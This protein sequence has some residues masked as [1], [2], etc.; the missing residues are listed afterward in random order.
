M[1]KMFEKLNTY[2]KTLKDNV[3]LDEMEFRPLKDF[4][5]QTLNVDGFFFTT[6]G[7]YGKQVVVVA[8]NCKINMPKRAVET[9]EQIAADEVLLNAMLEGH[10]QLTDIRE[11][12]T[13]N[14]TSTSYT[15]K[16]C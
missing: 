8:N 10:L 14:G 1:E 5:G 12:E 3:K 13:R 11:I 6:G 15:F 16:D 9:F 2:A 7:K 4:R